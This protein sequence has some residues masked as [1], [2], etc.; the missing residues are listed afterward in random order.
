MATGLPGDAW[1]F[2][3]PLLCALTIFRDFPL[4]RFQV[5]YALACLP[6]TLLFILRAYRRSR[7]DTGDMGTFRRGVLPGVQALSVQSGL[8]LLWCWLVWI[9]PVLQDRAGLD[10]S[11]LLSH[12]GWTLLLAFPSVFVLG[13]QLSTQWYRTRVLSRIWRQYGLEGEAL[14]RA[15]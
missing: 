12:V 5:L 14:N 8:V 2:F 3:I 4:P 10:W 11:V 7:P 13:T 1:Y 6:G 9:R 15:L